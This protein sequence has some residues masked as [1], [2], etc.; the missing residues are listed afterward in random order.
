MECSLV[1][2]LGYHWSLEVVY[3]FY[4]QYLVENEIQMTW[5]L[6]LAKDPPV[7]QI[8]ALQ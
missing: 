6:L 3:N 1:D 8:F 2:I 4:E 7:H 5:F